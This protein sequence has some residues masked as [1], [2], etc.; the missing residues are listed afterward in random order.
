M[1]SRFRR[2]IPSPVVP[3]SSFSYRLLKRGLDFTAASLGL[4]LG[5]PVIAAVATAV[6]VSMGSPVFYRH[7]RPGL[8]EKL[9]KLWKFRTMSNE[10]GPDGA[11]LPDALRLA[12]VGRFIRENSLD[13]LP[14][15]I[16]VLTGDMSLVGPRPLLVRYLPRYSEQQ[17]KRHDVKP[18]IT[19]WAQVNGRNALD[20]DSRLQHDSWYAE[21][22]SLWL[23]LRILAVTPLRLLS[24]TGVLAGAGAELDEFWGNQGVPM[25]VR[26]FP[27]EED[28]SLA[29]R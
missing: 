22:C 10:R 23:D 20:W 18:G 7:V 2:Q 28:E 25:G 8:N 17:K 5:L 24:R 15:L 11:L 26:A 21:N 29:G 3:N 6:R 19:G 12:P 14:Q 1:G 27:V 13:E 16:N 4:A 9:F